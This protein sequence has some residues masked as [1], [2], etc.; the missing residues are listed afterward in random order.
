[1]KPLIDWNELNK[2]R[3]KELTEAQTKHLVVKS[4]VVQRLLMK[5]NKKKNY[6]RVYTEFPVKEGKICDVYFENTLTKEAIAF[7]IQDKV[8]PQWLGQVKLQYS[9]W[10]VMGCRTSWILIDLKT[11]SNNIKTMSKQL[12]ELIP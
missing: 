12:E 5:Y 11:L 2:I 4:L 3:V 6:I 9:N 7:E 1:M 10:E 8:T